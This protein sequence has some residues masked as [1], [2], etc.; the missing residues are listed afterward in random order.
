MSVKSVFVYF[1]SIIYIYLV[2]INEFSYQE[3]H[4]HIL[5]GWEQGN[6]ATSQVERVSPVTIGIRASGLNGGNELDMFLQVD[7]KI[8]R[9]LQVKI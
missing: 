9:W 7:G 6:L 2:K 5:V 4:R 3:L 8:V 1:N